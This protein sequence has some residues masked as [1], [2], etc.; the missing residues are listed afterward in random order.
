MSDGLDRGK[1]PSSAH[2]K[3]FPN[4]LHLRNMKVLVLGLVYTYRHFDLWTYPQY[5][6]TVQPVSLVSLPLRLSVELGI[7]S[8]VKL[9]L[10]RKPNDWLLKK[11]R[12]A[13]SRIM[14]MYLPIP[15]S[16][17]RRM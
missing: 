14:Y 13:L 12:I 2:L 7:S 6:F 3:H 8:T 16:L 1:H 11:V 17:P 10:Q 5:P 15:G 9:D 4:H